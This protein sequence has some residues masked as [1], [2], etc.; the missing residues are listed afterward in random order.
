MNKWT[1]LSSMATK[2]IIV[3]G[4]PWSGKSTT[5]QI[6]YDILKD[7]GVN[8]ELYCEGNYNHPADFDGVSY[9][10][11]KEFNIL[12][13][14]HSTSRDL[15]NKIKINY[16]NGYL[17]PTAEENYHGILRSVIYAIS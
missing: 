6:V 12:Q 11:S 14:G 10:N 17:I 8:T 7:K 16:Y 5:A 3:E 9:F 15:L 4:L 1:H 2:L 13:Q